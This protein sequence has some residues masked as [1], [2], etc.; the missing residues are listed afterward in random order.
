MAIT[1]HPHSGQILMCDFTTGFKPPEMVKTRPVIVLT[2]QLKGRGQLV[3]VVCLSTA[4]PE[5]VMP[6]HCTVPKAELPMTSFFQESE[7]WV[8]GDLIYTVGFARLSP[9]SIRVAGGRRDYYR[10]KLNDERMREIRACV[11]HGLAMGALAD[12]LPK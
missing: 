10:K 6:Y 5:P 1:F 7:S 4:R 8:K 12:H 9:V 11:L 3:T 2:P